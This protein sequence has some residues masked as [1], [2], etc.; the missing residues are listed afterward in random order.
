MQ[1]AGVT[2]GMGLVEILIAIACFLAAIVP[3]MGIFSFSAENAKVIQAKSIAYSSA[4]EII[5]QV[6]LVP[7]A[8][9]PVSNTPYSLPMSGGKTKIGTGSLS[10]ELNLSEIPIGFSREL[11]IEKD[12]DETRKKATVK[13]EKSGITRASFEVSLT[14]AQN[15]GGRK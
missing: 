10:L 6:F 5:G 1:K 13:I 7:V 15:L 12:P 11:K 14:I 4:Q 2:R 3:L 9:L 8:S